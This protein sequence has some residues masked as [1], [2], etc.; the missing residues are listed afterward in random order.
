MTTSAGYCRQIDKKGQCGGERK[1]FLYFLRN[2][3][4]S[5]L[6][7]LFFYL[8]REGPSS[9][10]ALEQEEVLQIFA[11]AIDQNRRPR[12]IPVRIFRSTKDCK[13]SWYTYCSPNL[14]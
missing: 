1:K 14:I 6:A 2:G 9:A 3:R 8:R 7:L 4:I 13:F 12:K 5:G 11:N 10:H